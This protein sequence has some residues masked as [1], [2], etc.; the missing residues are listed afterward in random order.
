MADEVAKTKE[1]A[2]TVTNPQKQTGSPLVN[3]EES[4]LLLEVHFNLVHHCLKARIKVSKILFL[5]RTL[6]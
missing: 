4:L 5:E 1:F 3:Q 2:E 6:I